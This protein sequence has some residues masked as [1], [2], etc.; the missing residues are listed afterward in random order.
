MQKFY[1]TVN[2]NI[3]KE[4][5]NTLIS[6]AKEHYPNLDLDLAINIFH[7]YLECFCF[8]KDIPKREELEYWKSYK[9]PNGFLVGLTK[10]E[11]L[12]YKN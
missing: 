12:D 10:K 2:H 6:E 7:N 5:F 4:E 3:I 11:L 1:D 8:N 9:I